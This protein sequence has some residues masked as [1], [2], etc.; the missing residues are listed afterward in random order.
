MNAGYLIILFILSAA[1]VATITAAYGQS[2]GPN[3]LAATTSQA[4]RNIQSAEAA[5]ADVS[6]LVTRFNSALELQDQAASGRFVDCQS[7]DECIIESNNILL[8]VVEDSSSLAIK[9]TAE[10]EQAKL[11]MFAVY[12]PVGSFIVSVAVVAI[13]RMWQSRRARRY[14]EMDIHRTGVR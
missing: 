13:F 2:S 11:M 5:G 9:T 12:A 7:Y 6:D 3:I 1:G 4:L 8:S 14:Q 10:S